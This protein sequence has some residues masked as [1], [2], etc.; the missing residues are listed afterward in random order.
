MT[1][2]EGAIGAVMA[3]WTVIASLV[4]KKYAA[5]TAPKWKVIAYTVLV[6][7]P[8]WY[9]S[10]GKTGLFGRLNLPGL[11]SLHVEPKAA[12]EEPKAEAAPAELPHREGDDA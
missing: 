5:P 9:A 4:S 11:P 12:A 6:D 2:L 7:M 3:V 10:V 1:K 8:A